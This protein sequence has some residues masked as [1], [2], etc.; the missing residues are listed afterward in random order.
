MPAHTLLFVRAPSRFDWA[1]VVRWAPVALVALLA[2]AGVG[3]EHPW[4]G[5]DIARPA[6]AAA[7][8]LPLAVRSTR[9][10]LAAIGVGVAFWL[11]VALGGSLGLASVL[12]M[13]MVAY[14]CGRWCRPAWTAAL[15]TFFVMACAAG[16]LAWVGLVERVEDLA[17]PLVYLTASV[18]AGLLVR[19]QANQT[20]ELA[21]LNAHLAVQVDVAAQLAAATE[22]VR[23]ARDLHDSLAHTL[24]VTVVQAEAA[25]VALGEDERTDGGASGVEPR[26]RARQGLR[27]IQET[28]RRGLEDLRDTLRVLHSASE[29][30]R[31]LAELDVLARVLGDSGLTVETRVR[32]AV[33]ALPESLSEALY[34]IAQ[35]ALTNVVRH[36]DAV[37]AVVEVEIERDALQLTITDPGPA[38]AAERAGARR[39]IVGMRERLAPWL[40]EVDAGP[41]GSGWQVRAT[42]PLGG[43]AR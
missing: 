4:A 38:V 9:P 7:L 33:A 27:Q 23:L 24:T 5:P 14:S 3:M 16:A 19:R 29:A 11:Q 22:R 12:A 13:I 35:E 31:T 30:P 8:A 25:E 34:R 39:G 26:E 21:R 17:F 40:G 10:S 43:V 42:V 41:T 6:V 20:A 18:A 28:S 36:S 15:G 1:A 32:G 2:L 37:D